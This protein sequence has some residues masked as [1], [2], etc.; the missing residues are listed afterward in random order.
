MFNRHNLRLP[1][2][3]SNTMVQALCSSKHVWS[4][5]C[6]MRCAIWYHLY[7]LKNVKNT[8]GGVLILWLQAKPVTLLKLTP[9]YG[10]FSGFLNCIN[11]TKSRHAPPVAISTG[12]ADVALIVLVY[13]A[14]H[15]IST[16]K[17]IMR[18]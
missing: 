14:S 7:N 18:S 6:V 2:T 15:V 8:H 3:Y 4:Q 12:N 11:G 16:C 1:S 10:C 5:L 17:K 9:L 13:S